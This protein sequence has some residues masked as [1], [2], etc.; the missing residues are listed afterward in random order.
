MKNLWNPAAHEE[1]VAR[2]QRVTPDARAKWGTMNAEKMLCHL[3]DSLRMTVGDTHPKSKKLPIRY[4]PLKQLI[5][6]V[7]PFP[8][9]APT[10]PELLQTNAQA[11]EES[12]QQL[13][14]LIDRFRNSR[15]A[16]RPE[17]PA[18][19]KL[20]ERAWGALTYKHIDHHLRQF[21]V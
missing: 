17:H 8:K 6:Y 10:A 20:T 9:G 21:G 14:A 7:F 3:I 15:G 12:R 13:A 2:L 5:I 4:F 11:V 18:F 1:I 19:G 16:A